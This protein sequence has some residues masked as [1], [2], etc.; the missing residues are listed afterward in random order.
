[1]LSQQVQTY[2]KAISRK[3]NL[4]LVKSEGLIASLSQSEPQDARSYR[5]QKH[6]RSSEGSQAVSDITYPK[7]LKLRLLMSSLT[8]FL[9]N[10]IPASLCVLVSFFNFRSYV[11]VISLAPFH[12]IDYRFINRYAKSSLSLRSLLQFGHKF[13]RVTAL[14]ANVLQDYL[15]EPA[16]GVY[17]SIPATSTSYEG[18]SRGKV[19]RGSL[20]RT[21]DRTKILY[22]L[23]AS[24][25]PLP[26]PNDWFIEAGAKP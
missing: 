6:P 21:M 14:K 12:H 1:M 15:N 22:I 2:S 16:L 19:L 7:Y 25:I 8:E 11:D 20:F 23:R 24:N 18:R 4:Q 5:F 13:P 10:N 17:A 9:Q 26:F 3:A